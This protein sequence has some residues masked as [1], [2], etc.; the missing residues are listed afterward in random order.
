MP[1]VILSGAPG[2]GK[3]TLALALA[4]HFKS[5][6]TGFAQSYLLAADDLFET[7]D[8]YKFDVSRLSEAHGT[9]F[10]AYMHACMHARMDLDGDYGPEPLIV[11]HNTSLSNW[12]RAPYVQC[13]QAY[14]LPYVVVSLNV[15]PLESGPRNVHEVPPDRLTQM[16]ERREKLLPFWSQMVLESCDLSDAQEKWVKPIFAHF[17]K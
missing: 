1:I 14:D 12:E 17:S 11:V 8:G 15:H 9:C 10:R 16:W 4:R 3:T 2:S 13:A 6:N 7:P 5:L